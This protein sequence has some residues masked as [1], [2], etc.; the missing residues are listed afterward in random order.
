MVY[1]VVVVYQEQVHQA[2][3]EHQAHLVHQAL[4]EHQVTLDCL[5]QLERRVLVASQAS[6][7]HQVTP[8]CQVL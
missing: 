2:L 4:A 6:A 1:Q 7:V 3:A 5:E 8:G